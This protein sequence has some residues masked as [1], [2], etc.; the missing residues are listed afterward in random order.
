MVNVWVF[1]Y[2]NTVPYW[3]IAQLARWTS[4]HDKSIGFLP[5]PKNVLHVGPNKSAYFNWASS[6]QA[7]YFQ[8]P[9]YSAVAFLSSFTSRH[10]LLNSTEPEICALQVHNPTENALQPVT[11]VHPG[12]SARVSDS[13]VNGD[14]GSG[15]LHTRKNAVGWDH[16]GCHGPSHPS[17]RGILPQ[18]WN[19]VHWN[20]QSFLQ[21]QQYWWFPLSPY[22]YTYIQIH[23]SLNSASHCTF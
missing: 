6:P 5:I 14:G 10:F 13:L 2:S 9:N 1:C 20:A 18:K 11:K 15:E 8:F 19:L 23:F 7:S 21:F 16:S 17:R 22:T 3:A 12:E 4:V